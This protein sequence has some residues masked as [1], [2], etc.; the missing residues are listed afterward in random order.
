MAVNF[1]TALTDLAAG[2]AVLPRGFAIG[3][4][5]PFLTGAVVGLARTLLIVFAIGL[6]AF[7]A[8]GFVGL[9]F[10]EGLIFLTGTLVVFTGVFA[11]LTGFVDFLCAGTLETG[12][13]IV[14]FA[15]VSLIS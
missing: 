9:A 5:L 10:T 1:G 2:L 11:L 14:I 12:F 8:I 6:T 13:F 4:A 3:L 15:M 7:L